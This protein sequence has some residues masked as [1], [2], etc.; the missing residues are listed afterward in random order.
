[1][2][3]LSGPKAHAIAAAVFR[4]AT[5]G[6]QQGDRRYIMGKVSLGTDAA[7]L[8]T[9][10]T[11]SAPASFTGEDAAEITV[12]GSPWVVAHLVERA[13]ANG[14]RPA[15]PGEFTYRAF[16]HGKLDLTRAEALDALISASS[17]EAAREAARQAAGS[18]E[19]A[20]EALRQHLLDSLAEL[21]AAIDFH[22]DSVG[23]RRIDE[24]LERALTEAERWR[25]SAARSRPLV[26][27]FRIAINGPPN[28]GKS[29]LFNYLLGDERAIVTTEP[30][31]TRDVL[32]GHLLL[33]GLALT[34]LDTAGERDAESAAE[35]EGVRRSARARELADLVLEVRDVTAPRA[36]VGPQPDGS[37]PTLRV[38]T[39][40]DLLE[41]RSPEDRS[42]AGTHL[43]SVMTGEGMPDLLSDLGE[44]AMAGTRVDGPAIM[45]PRQRHVAELLHR[46]VEE[47]L[48]D[49][50]LGR[51]E[52]YVAQSLRMALERLAELVGR[53]DL[54]DVY[55]RIF[56][57]FCVG[58]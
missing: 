52:E 42:A 12:H 34:L 41:A 8:A 36:A 29:S 24:T 26:D 14:A 16:C 50:R 31:T 39:K 5:P 1:M 49:R 46:H 3:R 7:D 43:V 27:G 20:A 22:D 48:R 17:P 54:E 28:A 38:Y 13:V 40:T 9:C 19:R 4:P 32:E 21:E 56:Q 2:V 47:A 6:G 25:S 53:S 11:F 23:Q 18:V 55:Q 30:G 37:R 35:A 15:R 51:P 10:V 44:R 57:R 58:K 45:I 33:E